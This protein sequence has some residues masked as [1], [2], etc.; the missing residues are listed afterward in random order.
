M[1]TRGRVGYPSDLSDEEYAAVAPHLPRARQ[2]GERGRPRRHP[3]RAVLDG[4]FYVVK[5][6]CQWRQLPRDYPPWRT[7][8]HYFRRWRLDG[9]WERLHVALRERVRTAAGRD[10]Q[11][12]TG[13]IDSQSVKTTGVGGER[14]YDGGKKIR[15]RK[16]HILVDTL[17]LVLRVRVHS[18]AVS[19][20]HAVPLVL[21]GAD[22]AFPRVARVWADLGYTAS[23]PARG[24]AWIREQLGWHVQLSR[25]PGPQRAGWV[26]GWSREWPPDQRRSEWVAVQPLPRTDPRR[27]L[28]CRWIVERTFSWFGGSRRL[29]KDYERLP[30]TSE[31]LV[32]ITMIRLMARR[33]ARAP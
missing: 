26:P 2:P 32:L 3:L 30:A 9:I 28:P 7:V 25:P 1:A 16:R 8:Y 29:A 23:N 12:S 22:R 24:A 6:G 14:G 11:P 20:R 15:G 31:V 17:G 10:P 19:D 27:F 21:A 4:I 33:L 5:T 13:I 18:A